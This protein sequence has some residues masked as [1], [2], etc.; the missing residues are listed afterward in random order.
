M[1]L[2]SE[3]SFGV[4]GGCDGADNCSSC[5]YGVTSPP[6]AGDGIRGRWRLQYLGECR[7][8]YRT[9]SDLISEVEIR[10]RSLT[11]CVCALYLW[12]RWPHRRGG[13]LSQLIFYYD[14][15]RAMRIVS[16]PAQL[17]SSPM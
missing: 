13:Y 14:A 17:E 12:D 7:L 11:L 9:R 16:G 5:M 6:E 4:W 3:H 2:L 8:C 15:I 10:E 1:R